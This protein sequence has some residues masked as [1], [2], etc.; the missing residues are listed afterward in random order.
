MNANKTT[1]SNFFTGAKYYKIPVYQRAYSWSEKE[2]SQFLNDLN[3][4]G[5]N[6]YFFR[7]VLLQKML[8]N[9]I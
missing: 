5:A 6:N 1:I 4:N 7:N 9:V 3:E 8:T 2:W